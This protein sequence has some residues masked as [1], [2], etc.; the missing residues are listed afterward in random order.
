MVMVAMDGSGHLVPF[1]DGEPPPR[2]DNV[3]I[4]CYNPIVGVWVTVCI[5]GKYP[6][7]HNGYP[8]VWFPAVEAWKEYPTLQ[9]G[10]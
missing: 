9:G 4:Y 6:C 5:N 10:I 2:Y 1:H 7:F 3:P 8:G